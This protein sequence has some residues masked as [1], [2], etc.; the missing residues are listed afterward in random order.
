[1]S[2]T[3]LIARC[4][5]KASQTR[6][7]ESRGAGPEAT[8]PSDGPDM[9]RPRGPGGAARGVLPAAEPSRV[10]TRRNGPQD[11]ALRH[12]GRTGHGLFRRVFTD[13]ARV[14]RET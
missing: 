13:H 4:R 10:C 3:C 9:R 5:R 7:R 14:T 2:P 8:P 12:A 11:W 6:L 1:M